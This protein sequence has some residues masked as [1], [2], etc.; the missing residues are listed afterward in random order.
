MV[1]MYGI[2]EVNN[3]MYDC[4]VMINIGVCFD[5]CVIG[6]LDVFLL[7]FKK[8]Y[9]DID[10]LFINKNVLV[11]VFVIGDCGWVLGEFLRVWKSVGYVIFVFDLELWWL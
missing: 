2:F 8:I 10:F 9:V 11:D 6:C 5:D 1:G 4:D 7:D 3:V